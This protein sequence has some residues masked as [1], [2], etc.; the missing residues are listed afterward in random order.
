MLLVLLKKF[1][2]FNNLILILTLQTYFF[3]FFILYLRKNSQRKSKWLREIFNQVNERAKD[4]TW[5]VW[6]PS[7]QMQ[8]STIIYLQK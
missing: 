6:P 8:S 7:L 2:T 1:Y 4:Q 5:R 3:S